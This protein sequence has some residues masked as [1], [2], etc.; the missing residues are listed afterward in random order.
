MSQKQLHPKLMKAENL[1][2]TPQLAGFPAGF[3]GYFPLAQLVGASSKQLDCPLF[4]FLF[5]F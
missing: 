3:L 1:K 5:F 4:L 2:H